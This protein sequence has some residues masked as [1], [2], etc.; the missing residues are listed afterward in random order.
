MSSQR[1]STG[2]PPRL[3]LTNDLCK[4][5][6]NSRS[7]GGPGTNPI[8]K[9]RALPT[10]KIKEPHIGK[11]KEPHTGK[12]K[13]PHTGKTKEP[14]TGKAWELHTGNPALSVRGAPRALLMYC[15]RFLSQDSRKIEAAIQTRCTG[16]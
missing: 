14:H 16:I 8:G 3:K 13:E 4:E 11:T 1:K 7:T 12:T 6:A 5:V 9:T 2:S 15:N 10:G